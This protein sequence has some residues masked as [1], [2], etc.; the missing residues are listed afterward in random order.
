MRE[1]G[2]KECFDLLANPRLPFLLTSVGSGSIFCPLGA[3]KERSLLGR[4]LKNQGAQF[5]MRERDSGAGSRG[6]GGVLPRSLVYD[7]EY[8]ILYWS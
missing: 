4:S 6:A 1:I 5:F 7:Y 3:L 2:M 8:W